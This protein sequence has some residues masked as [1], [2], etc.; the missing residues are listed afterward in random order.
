MTD[1]T[2]F[3]DAFFAASYAHVSAQPD[4]S[5]H[6]APATAARFMPEA[7][8]AALAELTEAYHK[9]K[10]DPLF[11]AELTHLLRTYANRPSLLTDAER[12]SAD[13]GAR[14]SCSSA[15]TSTTPARTRSTTCSAR[16]C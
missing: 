1:A 2:P 15:R 11:Q 14:G 16:R 9:S 3:S 8:M 6:F 13:A 7:L 5:G 10:N 4:A 12:L